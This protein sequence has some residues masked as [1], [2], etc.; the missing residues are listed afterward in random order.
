MTY[1]S[2]G[3]YGDCIMFIGRCKSQHRFPNSK[4]KLKCLFPIE[5]LSSVAL[6]IRSCTWTLP[7]FHSDEQDRRRQRLRRV[8]RSSVK[9]YLIGSLRPFFSFS[10]RC[11]LNGDSTAGVA[12]HFW[13]KGKISAKRLWR[14]FF[15]L[16]SSNS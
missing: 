7:A 16:Q 2:P 12:K 1:L 9:R 10:L 8:W 6:K 13:C 5:D 3:L 15:F 14:A 11:I 4:I